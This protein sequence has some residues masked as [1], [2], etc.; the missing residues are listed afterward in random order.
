VPYAERL[1]VCCLEP[2]ELRRICADLVMTFKIVKG[3]VNLCF[4]DFFC[5]CA[6]FW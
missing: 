5:L 3:I 6:C 2:L 1:R 4:D